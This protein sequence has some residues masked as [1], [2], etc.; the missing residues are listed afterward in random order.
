MEVGMV[1][2]AE[3]PEPPLDRSRGFWCGSRGSLD[4]LHEGHFVQEDAHLPART[5]FEEWVAGRTG[6]ERCTVRSKARR[7][8]AAAP[9]PLSAVGG[10]VS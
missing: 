4:S 7:A 10:E 9:V 3:E 1:S 5:L 2:S 6:R 8:V